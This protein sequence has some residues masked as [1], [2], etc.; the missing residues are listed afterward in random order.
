M[1]L[2]RIENSA[3]LRA[4]RDRLSLTQTQ[5]A[6]LFQVPYNTY[7]GWE[8]GRRDAQGLAIYLLDDASPLREIIQ[9]NNLEKSAK[10]A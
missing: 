1:R 4:L 9:E 10:K 5:M 7:R 6:E 3:Q 8:I 2:L